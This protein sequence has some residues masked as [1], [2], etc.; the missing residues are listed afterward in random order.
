MGHHPD[1]QAARQAP[2]AAPTGELWLWYSSASP[3]IPAG[4]YDRES[5]V[6]GLDSVR[7]PDGDVSRALRSATK[8]VRTLGELLPGLDD[9]FPILIP[10]P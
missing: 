1:A 9:F 4:L 10:G 5:D 3:H 2:L 8:F 7:V 6:I